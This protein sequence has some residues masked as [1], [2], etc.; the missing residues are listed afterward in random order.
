LGLIDLKHDLFDEMIQYNL[1]NDQYESDIFKIEGHE[2]P[3]IIDIPEYRK[4]FNIDQAQTP[5]FQEA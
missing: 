1:V 5:E 4:K 3:P 2:R